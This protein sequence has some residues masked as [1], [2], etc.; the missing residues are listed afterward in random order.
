VQKTGRRPLKINSGRRSRGRKSGVE[1][2]W[3]EASDGDLNPPI[4]VTGVNTG[5]RAKAQTRT[6]A[7]FE[8]KWKK[9]NGGG[10]RERSFGK[11]ISNGKVRG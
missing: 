2:A 4:R 7:T 11:S 10:G 1:S 9:R 8:G 6:I 5:R 3:D